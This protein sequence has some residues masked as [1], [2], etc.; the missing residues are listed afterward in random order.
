MRKIKV[1][2]WW[3]AA[4]AAV[5]VALIIFTRKPAGL[6]YKT[7]KVERGSITSMISATGT[8]NAVTSVDVG[9]QVSGIIQDILVDFN[10]EVKKGQL[11]AQID[12][13]PFKAK[14][15]QADANLTKARIAVDDSKRTLDRNTELFAKNL[16]AR[17]DKDAAET[18]YQ[19][20]LAQ[21]KQ[22][23]ASYDLA[24]TDLKNTTITSPISGIVVNRNM[25]PGQTVAASF[26]APTLFTIA[27]DLSEMQIEA[28]IDEGD[29]GRIKKGQ[30]AV[31]TVDAFPEE[32]FSG[33]VSQVRIAPEIVQRVVTYTVV[34]GVS[35]D[36]LLLKPGMTANISIVTDRRNDIFKVANTALRFKPSA[37]VLQQIAQK[38]NNREKPVVDTVTEKPKAAGRERTS[39]MAGGEKQRALAGPEG[40]RGASRQEQ[41]KPAGNFGTLWVFDGKT[42]RS[43]RVKTGI[44]DGVS[45]EVES[46]EIAE[47]TQAVIGINAN[48]K[49]SGTGTAAPFG[50]GGPGMRV[51]R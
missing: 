12:P 21:M 42:I 25:N 13:A 5:V 22:A 44:T 15:D 46:Q 47:G 34:I 38:N 29:I 24:M 2:I 49:G 7:V 28:N 41:K 32:N 19:N 30:E 36:E 43:V 9:S 18:T 11:I 39:K 14:L 31:F 48:G 16:I 35:N 26:S 33:R 3:F 8:V 50:M 45:T 23:Q 17:S 51:R 6:S 20:A 4:A 27:Q 37:D 40:Q 10:S 1:K